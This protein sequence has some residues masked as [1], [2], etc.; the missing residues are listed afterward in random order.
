ATGEPAAGLSLVSEEHELR[1]L[2]LSAYL[3]E[4]LMPGIF[5]I[6]ENDSDELRCLIARRLIV[7]LPRLR[8][9]RLLLRIK[10]RHRVAAEQKVNSYDNDAAN[11]A[12]HGKASAAG[13]ANIFNILAFSSSLPEHL[14]N[15]AWRDSF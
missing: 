8:Y 15:I 4:D 14:F 2:V 7:D 12:A 3:P 10:Q 1:L 6:G 11:S 5:G 9:L 13:S